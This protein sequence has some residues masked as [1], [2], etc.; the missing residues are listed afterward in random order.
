[1]ISFIVP[2]YNE[3]SVIARTV[4]AIH[5]AA[6]ESG[7]PY[8]VIVAN[9]ASTDAT[10]EIARQNGATVVD[11]QCRQIAGTRN[12]G[13]RASRGERL[14][15]VDADTIINTRALQ[16]ALRAF[17]RGAV[18]GGSL[19]RFEGPVPLYAKLLL[20]WLGFFMRVSGISSGAFMFCTRAAFDAV[21]GFDERMFGGE[22]AAMSAALQRQGCFVVIGPRVDT[23]GRRVRVISGLPLLWSL[24]RMAFSPSG[25]LRN[26]EAVKK[27]WYNPDRS[28]GPTATFLTQISNAVALVLVAMLVA[29][30]L[31][32]I[33]WPKAIETGPLG[34]LKFFGSTVVNHVGLVLW[35]CAWHLAR[36]L[37]QAPRWPE[38]L[39]IVLIVGLCLWFAWRATTGVWHFWGDTFAQTVHVGV[40]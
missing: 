1:M 40:K 32:M 2:A 34:Q 37:P 28:E 19:A 21:G 8:Q 14:I 25:M 12:A 16:A 5:A 10:A 35:P 13:A 20:F 9:D 33:P 6:R 18:G 29:V 4:Q 3:E 39:K 24:V 27:I 38:R 15:F 36:G 7:Q 17:E 30:P 23:S 26:R 22:D 11:V 31:W